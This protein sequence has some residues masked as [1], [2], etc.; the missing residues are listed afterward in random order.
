MVQKPKTSTEIS[1]LQRRGMDEATVPGDYAVEVRGV[2]RAT[3]AVKGD[4]VD[5]SGRA[6]K[7]NG[8]DKEGGQPFHTTH[9]GKVPP[10]IREKIFINLLALPPPYAGRNISIQDTSTSHASK[11][12]GTQVSS[13]T[14]CY[15]LKK[16]WLKALQTCRQI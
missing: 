7:S 12:G 16:S 3:L 4:G 1:A 14:P 5:N 6:D 8:Y 9:L 15:H 2:G 11:A 13:S 10:E